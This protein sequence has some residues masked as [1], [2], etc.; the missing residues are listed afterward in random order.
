MSD[1]II[2]VHSGVLRVASP[3]FM[4]GFDNIKDKDFVGM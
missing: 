3:F 1:V 4:R 2:N